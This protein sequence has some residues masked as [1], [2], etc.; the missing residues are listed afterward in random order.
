MTNS[1][2]LQTT[3]QKESKGRTKRLNARNNSLHRA[4][5][6]H[7]CLNSCKGSFL[8][9]C[10]TFRT[11]GSLRIAKTVVSS[12]TGRRRPSPIRTT[13]CD[14]K[15]PHHL[16]IQSKPS[17]KEYSSFTYRDTRGMYVKNRV[18]KNSGPL[19]SLHPLGK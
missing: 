11:N 13:L 4:E 8:F 6:L 14:P 10:A 5:R 7:K 18:T 16:A 9:R 15:A 19:V 17:S 2:L 1:I 3:R 12:R